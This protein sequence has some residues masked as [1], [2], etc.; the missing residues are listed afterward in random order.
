MKKSVMAS[1]GFHAAIL[2]AALVSL[3][4]KE[5]FR[6]PPVDAIQVDISQIKDD[7]KRKATTTEDTKKMA[8]PAPK[9]TET[10]APEPAP[11]V[12]DEIKTAAKEPVADVTPPEPK[13]EEP[14]KAVLQKAEDKPL[15]PDPLKQLLAEDAKKIEEQKKAEEAK[16]LEEKKKADD[17]K[18]AAAK[19]LAEKKKIEKKKA[20]D[21]IQAFLNKEDDE[22]TAPQKP[23]DVSGTPETG[24]QNIAGKD[25]AISATIVD[26][27]VNKVKGCFTVPPA[28]RDADINVKVHFQLSRDGT[29]TSVGAE[30]S[31]DPIVAATA[32]AA[33]SAVKGCEPYELPPDRYDLW[34]DVILN[35]NPNM[36]FRT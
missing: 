25:D 20:F 29:V 7:S 27:L 36:L 28:A 12:A 14:K 5:A 17:V 21:D 15:S 23:T 18:K 26:A 33:V 2:M 8:K 35:F 31:S 34:K 22:R 1:A 13:K 3:P 10:V 11:K 9:K 4:A 24:E 19:K 6:A 30:P 32:A 16:K